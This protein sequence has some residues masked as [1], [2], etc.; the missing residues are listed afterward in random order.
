MATVGQVLTAPE[1]GWR[2]YDD[3]DSRLLYKGSGWIRGATYS[4]A[5]KTTLS[6]SYNYGDTINFKFYGSK[7]RLI[8]AKNLDRENNSIITIDGIDYNYNAYNSSTIYQVLIFEKTDLPL[9][10]HTVK[11]TK[12]TNNNSMDICLDAIDIDDTGYLMH[13]TLSQ[14]SSLDNMQVGDCIPCKYTAYSGYAGY[15]SELGTCIKDEIPIAGTAIPDGLF[16]LI[17]TDKGTLIADRVLQTSIS[18][19]NLNSAK[20]IEN[21]MHCFDNGVINPSANVMSDYSITGNFTEYVDTYSDMKLY[22][23]FSNTCSLESKYNIVRSLYNRGANSTNYVQ[24][25]FI[26]PTLIKYIIMQGWGY[27]STNP[28]L[29]QGCKGYKIEG[30]N[31]NTNY[32]TLVDSSDS[33]WAYFETI[34]NL[35]NNT[36]YKYYKITF[37][38]SN[39][40]DYGICIGRIRLYNSLPNMKIIRSLFGGC[41]YADANGNKTLTNASKGAWPTSNE[42]DKY[43]VNSDLKDKI[44][45]GDD[46]IWHYKSLFSWCK[47]TAINGTWNDGKGNSSTASNVHRILR[48]IINRNTWPDTSWGTS[49]NVD[50]SIGF[51]PVLNYVES[52]IA[53]EVIF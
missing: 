12:G 17:K 25:N 50:A 27:G 8:D 15:F 31:D 45:K 46:N 53:S 14:V 40:T 19:D 36:A 11:I 18:W 43:I 26:N 24:V 44:T 41:A 47:D 51:R 22:Y 32:T 4:S 49:S 28:S 33:I 52:D 5:Y 6:Y 37:K 21:H 34:I 3:G 30:S 20:Y 35:N 42:W 39:Y 16:Y 2:R 38:G 7:L 29:Q 13:P 10:I 48:G 23:A 1:S 9:G